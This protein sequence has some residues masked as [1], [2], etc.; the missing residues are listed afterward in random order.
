MAYRVKARY[1]ADPD[2]LGESFVL[3]SDNDDLGLRELEMGQ[4]VLIV[5]LCLCGKK[6]THKN[7][8]CDQCFQQGVDL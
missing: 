4:K 8:Y 7:R 5:P 2:Q 3:T 6:A 1:Y